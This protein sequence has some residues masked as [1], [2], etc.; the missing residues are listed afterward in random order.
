MHSQPYVA[1]R[2]AASEKYNFRTVHRGRYCPVKDTVG[3]SGYVVYIGKTEMVFNK[4][5]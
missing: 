4:L 2:P 1:P 3:N 5:K